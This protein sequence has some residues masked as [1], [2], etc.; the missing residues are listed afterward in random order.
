M[1]I[2][3]DLSNEKQTPNIR[4]PSYP[5]FLKLSFTPFP[6]PSSCPYPQQC[7]PHGPAVS[8]FLNTFL[9]NVPSCLLGSALPLGGSTLCWNHLCQEQGFPLQRPLFSPTSATLLSVCS[10]WLLS[11]LPSTPEPAMS[12]TAAR[13]RML[14]VCWE[15]SMQQIF[16]K[17]NS[18]SVEVQMTILIWCPSDKLPKLI[19]PKS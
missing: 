10:Q 8:P 13:W 17:F 16:T 15:T 12:T 3:I 6:T 18:L 4:T 9:T 11:W 1:K 5:P 19:H 14:G 2:K 7:L